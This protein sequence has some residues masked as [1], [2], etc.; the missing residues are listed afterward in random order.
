[1]A[2]TYCTAASCKM[3]DSLYNTYSVHRGSLH[4]KITLLFAMCISVAWLVTTAVAEYD[5][6]S[7]ELGGIGTDTLSVGCRWSETSV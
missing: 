3:N 4:G 6:S 1:M 2:M 5:S 7:L